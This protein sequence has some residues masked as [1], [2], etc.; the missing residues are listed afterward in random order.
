MLFGKAVEQL[1]LV[2]TAVR[3]LTISH[4]YSDSNLP[5]KSYRS[6]KE[7][8]TKLPNLFALKN[9]Y[10]FEFENYTSCLVARSLRRSFKAS[11]F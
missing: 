6:A 9:F 5:T 7:T 2:S 4:R 3:H 8:K 11:T 10:Q 1:Q